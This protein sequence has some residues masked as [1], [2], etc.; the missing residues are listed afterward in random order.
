VE[1]GAFR[2]FQR[3]VIVGYAFDL[4]DANAAEKTNALRGVYQGV[5]FG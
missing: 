5:A 3:Q 1:H 4:K 2:K